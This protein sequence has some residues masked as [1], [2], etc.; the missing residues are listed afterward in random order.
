MVP[1]NLPYYSCTFS[2]SRHSLV[3]ALTWIAFA[4]KALGLSTTQLQCNA[5]NI[6]RCGEKTGHTYTHK[7]N[8]KTVATVTKVAQQTPI[9]SNPQWRPPN[10]LPSSK[11]Q[12]SNPIQIH[13]RDHTGPSLSI[14]PCKAVLPQQLLARDSHLPINDQIFNQVNQ[15]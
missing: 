3:E 8:Q 12:A 15:S 13:L 9:Q 11:N 2:R 10:R 6:Q 1:R 4:A 7:S 5:I 14:L